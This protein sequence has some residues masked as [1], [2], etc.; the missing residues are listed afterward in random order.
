MTTY[1]KEAWGEPSIAEVFKMIGE[2][3]TVTERKEIL[4]SFA[5]NDLIEVLQQTYDPTV[6]FCCDVPTYRKNTPEKG[7]VPGY[8]MTQLHQELRKLY[9]WREGDPK[10]AHLTEQKKAD[11][12]EQTLETLC[13]EDAVILEGIIKKKQ[14]VKGLTSKSVQDVFPGLLPKTK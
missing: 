4:K 14:K 7:G 2:A 10:S 9:L 11:L 8:T 13:E 12:L 6:T 5:S 3:K 1:R